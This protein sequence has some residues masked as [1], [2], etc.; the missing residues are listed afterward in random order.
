MDKLISLYNNSDDKSELEFEARLCLQF[1]NN[2]KIVSNINIHQFQSILH[3]LGL[4]YNIES[5]FQIIHVFENNIRILSMNQIQQKILL[6]KHIQST[7]IPFIKIKWTLSKEKTIEN[8]SL[9]DFDITKSMYVRRKQVYKISLDSWDLYMIE[10]NSNNVK[11]FEIEFE[12]RNDDDC[13]L[14]ITLIHKLTMFIENLF[15][16]ENRFEIPIVKKL[17][18]LLAKKSVPYLLWNV[19]NK[20]V[21]L[22]FDMWNTICYNYNYFLKMDGIRYLLFVFNKK[23]YAINETHRILV[24]DTILPSN[25]VLDSELVNDTFYIFDILYYNGNDIRNRPTYFRQH[26]L[27]N[28][29]LEPYMELVELE[30]DFD[31]LWKY[32]YTSFPKYVDGVV[33]ISNDSTYKNTLTYKYKPSCLLTIDFLIW[34]DYR[35]HSINEHGDYV[36]FTGNESHPYENKP[37]D[38]TQDIYPGDIIEFQYIDNQFKPLKK[39]LDKTK[40]NFITVAIDVWEDINSPIDLSSFLL[41]ILSFK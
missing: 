2:S 14:E 15:S 27:K 20:P 25:T 8:M 13:N 32:V 7:S 35:L 24:H 21:N 5:Y 36:L 9:S 22:K 23:L 39:R 12:F 10:A 34:N 3:E 29:N 37:I 11:T 40:P 18:Q 17:N 30:S 16:S 1:K 26:I 6:E 19:I 33:F 4:K 28:I 31:L 41:N 38:V